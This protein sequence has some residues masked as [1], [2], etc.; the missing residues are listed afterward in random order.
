MLDHI[1]DSNSVDVTGHLAA[2]Q[3]LIDHQTSDDIRSA[4]ATP[5]TSAQNGLEAFQV[6]SYTIAKKFQ[7][8]FVYS[9]GFDLLA[10][11]GQGF[12]P[13]RLTQELISLGEILDA[14]VSVSASLDD[15]LEASSLLLRV[16]FFSLL[17]EELFKMGLHPRP[18]EVA[19]VEE[20]DFEAAPG[21]ALIQAPAP[22]PEPALEET[23]EVTSQPF[24]APVEVEATPT[25]PASTGPAPATQLAPLP[26][27]QSEGFERGGDVARPGEYLT[28]FLAE[29]EYAVETS[30]VQEII[31]LQPMARLPNAPGFVKGVINL[32][33]MVVPVMDLREKLGF[34]S[35]AY[36]KYTVIVVVRVKGKTTG[37][38]VDSVSEVFELQDAQIQPPPDLAQGASSDNVK[39]LGKFQD[40]FLILLSLN[41]LLRRE[42]L[43]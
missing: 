35:R 16:L 39:G 32:R 5:A 8:G 25:E 29:E 31:S 9:L 38:I 13:L 41:R 20:S 19:R 3:A 36:D 40:R 33:G 11:E 14:Q 10:L 4:M 30:Q 1:G 26:P 21:P 27:E 34:A 43:V 18:L 15:P 17:E 7:Q 42:E 24:D 37:L 6:D 2:L 28:F 23:P 12:N 22:T